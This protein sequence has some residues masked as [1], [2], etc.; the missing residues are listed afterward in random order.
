MTPEPDSYMENY[1]SSIGV[2]SIEDFRSF[3]LSRLV[4][5]I[6]RSRNGTL[7]DLGCGAGTFVALML[8]QGVHIL[9]V[10]PS[11]KQIATARSLLE[12][13]RLPADTV[14][15]A[16]VENLVQQKQTFQTIVLLDVL[17]HLPDPVQFL[18][19]IHPLLSQD[20]ILIITVPA[21]PHL[22]DERDKMFG[23]ILRYDPKTLSNQ[24]N[25]AGYRLERWQYWNLLGWL[26]RYINKNI[27]HSK[28]VL[29]EFR[30]S[31]SFISIQLNRLLRTYFLVVENHLRPTTGMT[32]LAVAR[33]E[34]D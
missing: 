7:L 31:D 24:L 33:L 1:W 27:L 12:Q 19:S 9:G 23:H 11:D 8:R 28:P 4:C 6:V 16:S 2:R 29:Y 34:Y 13:L 3:S 20:A 22:Y 25:Q 32:L 14:Q 18:R 26:Q 30:H 21:D 17:E 10:D 15:V 5:R